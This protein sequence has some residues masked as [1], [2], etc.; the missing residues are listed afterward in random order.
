MQIQPTDS[1]WISKSLL[2]RAEF[3][4]GQIITT[5]PVHNCACAVY[6]NLSVHESL[7]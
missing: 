6:C 1:R 4:E 5:P 7:Q 2:D 3:G